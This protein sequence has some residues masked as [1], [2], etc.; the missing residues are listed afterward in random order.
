MTIAIFDSDSIIYA[1]AAVGEER[2]I[3][4][5]HLP[6]GRVHEFKNKTEFYGRKKDRSGGWL[7]DL[8]KVRIETGK[9]PFPLEQF[10]IVEKQ[11]IKEPLPNILHTAKMMIGSS[12]AAIDAESMVCFVEGDT[13]LIRLQKSSMMEYKGGRDKLLKPLYKQDVADYIL[14]HHNG[15][16]CSDGHETDDH[17]IME[18]V[19][20]KKNGERAVVI[21]IDKDVAGAPV[22]SFNPQK[23][24]LGIQD[25]DCF[26]KLFLDD[27]KT[28]RGIGRI[29]NYWQCLY[30]DK[31][32]NYLAASH[33]EEKWGEITAF[34][35]LKDTQNDK[36]AWKAMYEGF[37]FLYPEPKK[38]ITW[39]G[40]EVEIDALYVFQEMWD[41]SMMRR[42]PD[43]V[44]DI[45]KVLKKYKII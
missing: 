21:T 13:P 10:E 26:G 19:K 33:S 12:I 40:D 29:Y 43:D 11:R 34:E 41:M 23:P 6:S 20:C 39:R 7:G 16:L 3:E 15:I 9:E 28:V 8:N 18:A 17:V 4:V 27:K 36:D 45:R 24:E 35:R 37:N 2:Y 14:K 32:D 22:L 25:G 30:G 31:T 1:A 5:K 42:H 44:V 38:I